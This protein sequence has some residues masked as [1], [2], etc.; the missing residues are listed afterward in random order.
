MTFTNSSLVNY[1]R[2][3]PNK[4]TNRKY[5]I[6]RITPHCVVGQATVERLGEMFAPT[7][8]EASANYGIGF[9]GRV[10]MYC[11]EKDRSWCSSS[12]DND[13]RAI[14]IECASD[15]TYP[16]A[17]KDAVYDKLIKLCIDICK[18]N[19]KTK[20]LW[21]GDKTKSLNYKPA[22]NEM[23][24]TVHR[25]FKNKSCPGDW[26]YARMGDLAAKV[27]AAL[28]PVV[29]TSNVLYKVQVGAFS[30]KENAENTVAK[31]KAAGFDAVIIEHKE[32]NKTKVE[33]PKPV[34]VIFNEGD[35]V[36]MSK[37]AVVYGKTIKFKSWV[38]N[39]VLYVRKVEGNKIKI[40]TA[41]TGAITGSVDKK[42]L[43]KI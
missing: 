41:I 42:Y 39:K 26:M 9:D 7:E 3:S 10:G 1:T 6:E 17:F 29:E 16:Y 40:S 15:N 2:I 27:T 21:F 25:W 23:V 19:G 8:S 36:R 14:T 24:L 33:E 5:A 35:K 22:S 38:Y 4:T 12:A 37:D 18:R 34:E 31:L 13:H 32:T 28:N 20:L 11:E 30:K 43:T